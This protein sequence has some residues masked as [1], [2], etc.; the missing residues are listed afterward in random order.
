MAD[1]QACHSKPSC[2]VAITEEDTIVLNASWRGLGILSVWAVYGAV[3]E[4]FFLE[5][6]AI[7]MWL[8]C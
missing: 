2:F 4:D 3:E 7:L 8:R 6:E 5:L 1:N